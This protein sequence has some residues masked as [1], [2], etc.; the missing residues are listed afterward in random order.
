MLSMCVPLT[1][2]MISGRPYS[3]VIR[4]PISIFDYRP[5]SVAVH[6]NGPQPGAATCNYS[7]SPV[8]QHVPHLPADDVPVPSNT[9]WRHIVCTGIEVIILTLLMGFL[10][11]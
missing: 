8:M 1:C 7:T 10:F 6:H 11:S 4:V 3:V 5:V 2:V 9:V